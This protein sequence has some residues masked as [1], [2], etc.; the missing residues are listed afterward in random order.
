MRAGFATEISVRAPKR[1][2]DAGE[3]PWYT[4]LTPRQHP[5]HDDQPR[6]HRRQDRVPAKS[7]AHENGAFVH[8]TRCCAPGWWPRAFGW[9]FCNR[10][11]LPTH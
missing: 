5:F 6:R 10:L 9:W 7:R 8:S 1:V 4:P 11:L 3:L 2:T